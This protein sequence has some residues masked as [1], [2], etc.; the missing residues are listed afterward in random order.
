M[1]QYNQ[2]K[3]RARSNTLRA[4][5][6]K[7]RGRRSFHKVRLSSGQPLRKL[8]CKSGLRPE[9]VCCIAL[10]RVQQKKPGVPPASV[11]EV[12][13][14][15]YDN[16]EDDDDDFTCKDHPVMMLMVMVMIMISC[17]GRILLRLP[18]GMKLHYA[19]KQQ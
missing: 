15:H 13:D 17:R 7:E 5:L 1:G 6:C 4:F 3:Q 2:T 19:A 8:A 9:R 12:P 18:Y 11:L 10:E 14:Q 16:D